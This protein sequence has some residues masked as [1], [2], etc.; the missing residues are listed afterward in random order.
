MMK[1]NTVFVVTLNESFAS[2]SRNEDVTSFRTQRKITR[3]IKN[4]VWTCGCLD[5]FVQTNYQRGI[6]EN[7]ILKY[8]FIII[9]SESLNISE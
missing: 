6:S 8:I 3:I 2:L 7:F 4:K 5:I 1:N 9:L